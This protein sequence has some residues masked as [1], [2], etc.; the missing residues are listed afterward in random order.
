MQHLT[1]EEQLKLGVRYFDL[2]VNKVD[3]EYVMFHS[4]LNGTKFNP[5][6]DCI[7]QFLEENPS[8]TLLL[9]FQH[10]KNSSDDYVYNEVS[11]RLKGKLVVQDESQNE[12]QYVDDLTLKETRGKCIV[13]FNNDSN[14][15]K[16][17][18]YFLEMMMRALKKASS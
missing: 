15:I 18:I 7:V 1:I 6:L 14:Y 9:D 10:F 4:V 11:E 5:I 3:N 12:L 8:E 17:N 2:R 16:E 13:F